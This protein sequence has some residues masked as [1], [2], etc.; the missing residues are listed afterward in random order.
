MFKLAVQEQIVLIVIFS[1]MLLF[2][3][4]III[5]MTLNIGDD[6][7][8]NK[9]NKVLRVVKKFLENIC[10]NLTTDAVFA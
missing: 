4:F 7:M 1:R 8:V 3:I 2:I 5:A 6:A 10:V 9:V